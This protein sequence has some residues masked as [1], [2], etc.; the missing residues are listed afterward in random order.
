MRLRLSALGL[1]PFVF[2]VTDMCAPRHDVAALLV[3]YIYTDNIALP[4]TP[5]H[6]HLRE[7]SSVSQRYRVKGLSALCDC[8][9]NSTAASVLRNRGANLALSAGSAFHEAEN[10]D[11]MRQLPRQMAGTLL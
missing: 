1:L 9:L 7:L 6:E 10:G 5:V 11:V 4:L 3:E 2:H 8:L